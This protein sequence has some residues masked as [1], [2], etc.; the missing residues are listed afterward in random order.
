MTQFAQLFLY[1]SKGPGTAFLRFVA[2]LKHE[3]YNIW[4]EKTRILISKL[5]YS[6]S[7]YYPTLLVI[8]L[9]VTSV[10]NESQMV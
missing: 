8:L 5:N 2:Y 10:S 7:V 1:G 4:L 9:K 3:D 6:V